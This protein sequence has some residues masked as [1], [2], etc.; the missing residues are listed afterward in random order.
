MNSAE[1][2]ANAVDVDL[3]EQ[4][5]HSSHI[6]LTRLFEIICKNLIR[7]YLE[8]NDKK[9]IFLY[10]LFYSLFILNVLLKETNRHNIRISE[11]KKDS[12]FPRQYFNDIGETKTLA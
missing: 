12:T 2:Y 10:N 3:V 6:L 4:N 7:Q 8:I 1:I 5:G 9:T 11:K